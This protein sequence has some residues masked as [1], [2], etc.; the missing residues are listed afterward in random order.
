MWHFLGYYDIVLFGNI[1]GAYKNMSLSL[2]LK[3]G[4]EGLEQLLYRYGHG[5]V[6]KDHGIVKEESIG[7][8]KT[9]KC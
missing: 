3:L 4:V 2:A 6:Q 9:E 5:V 1:P 8:S 7:N